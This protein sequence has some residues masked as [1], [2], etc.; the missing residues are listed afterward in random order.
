VV[1]H[2]KHRLHVELVR[3]AKKRKQNNRALALLPIIR[4][5]VRPRVR[6]RAFRRFRSPGAGLA[7]GLFFL[8]GCRPR[9]LGFRLASGEGSLNVFQPGGWSAASFACPAAKTFQTQNRFIYLIGLRDELCEDLTD[10]HHRSM[11]R[12]E[13]SAEETGVTETPVLLFFVIER[14]VRRMGRAVGMP[15]KESD[16]VV[17]AISDSVVRALRVGREG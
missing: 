5:C 11:P 1:H 3:K 10:V 14:G 16:A 2:V 4:P 9:R 17:S 12:F 6:L 7:V 8:P 15:L 13:R